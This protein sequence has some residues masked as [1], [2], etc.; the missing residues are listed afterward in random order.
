MSERKVKKIRYENTGEFS[1][2]IALQ[3]IEGLLKKDYRISK[4]AIGLLLL[5]EDEEIKSLIKER[6]P[7][8]EGEITSIISKTKAHYNKPLDYLITMR[9]QQEASQIIQRAISHLKK[10]NISFR[11]RLSQIMMNPIAGIPILFTVLYLGLY[12]FVGVFAAQTVVEF[13]EVTLFEKQISPWVREV[14]NNF[15][16]FPPI[17]DLFVGEYG[18]FTQAIPYAVALILP[19]VTAFFLVFSIIE[20]TGYLP[21]LAMLIDRIFKKIG[22]SGRSVIPMTLGFGCGTMAVM[23]TR[24]L[25]TKREKVISSLLL[26]LAIPCSAQ[27]G[28]I[29]ALLSNRPKALLIWGGVIILEF[30]FIGYLASLLLPGK[31]PSFFMEIPPLRI[32]KLSNVLK[33]TYSRVQWYFMEVFPLFILASILIWLGQLTG[34]FGLT[35]KALEPLVRLIGLP[36]ETAVVF[37]FGFFRRDYGAA[38]L[39]DMNREGIFSGV[40]L[41]VAAITLTLFMP[42]IAQFIMTAKERGMKAAILIALFIVPSAFLAGFFVNLILNALAVQL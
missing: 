4:R 28:I 40:Q 17:Q 9:R 3:K 19:I 33:K 11:E 25:E 36:D 34:I 27:L 32:P 14:F 6:E 29:F 22:L 38:G 41:V 12:Q 24:T 35:I 42:C 5:Q 15:V 39:L 30:L 2:E 31:T 26:A 8:I 20:D 23:V 16:G 7:D 13:L 21:R 18:I 10:K 1:I 37:L